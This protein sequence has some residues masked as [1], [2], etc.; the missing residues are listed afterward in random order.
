[1]L[2]PAA[3]SRFWADLQVSVDWYQI[4]IEDVIQFV[5]AE[6]SILNCYDGRFNPAYDASNHW[7]SNFARNS[8]SGTIDNA[9]AIYRNLAVLETRGIDLQLD[10]KIAA[11]RGEL[12]VAWYVGWVDSFQRQSDPVAAGEEQAGTI[13][14]FAG[15]YP[16][17]K[18]NF[19]LSYALD[20]VDVTGAWR[21]VDSMR[22]ANFPDFEVPAYNSFDLFASYR[23]KDGPLSGVTLSA[24]I[25]N[26]TN[27]DPPIFPTWSNANTDAS[28]YDVIG[29]RYFIGAR[30]SSF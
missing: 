12:G 26:L 8:T 17:W 20:G 15:A 25:E 27:Q 19:E 21:Y 9:I 10:W 1:V 18:W 30:Y 13:G 2:R 14:G 28:Q 24:G 5:S 16:E 22:D 7:C 4:E 23:I 29:R 11:G 6:E 3:A